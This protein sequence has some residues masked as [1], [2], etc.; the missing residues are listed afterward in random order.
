MYLTFKCVNSMP[1]KLCL[2]R[3]TTPNPTDFL[4]LLLESLKSKKE[5]IS[6]LEIMI[7]T[8][9]CIEVKMIFIKQANIQ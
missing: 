4:S 7:E 3:A 9:K 2:K 6:R 8:I 5:R 1:C